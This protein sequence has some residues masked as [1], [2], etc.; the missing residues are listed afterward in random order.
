MEVLSPKR[1]EVWWIAF[2]PSV[3][4]EIQKTRPA[5]IISNDKSNRYLDRFQVIP[6]TPQTDRVYPGEAI[7]EL[8]GVSVKV[9]CN[10]LSTSSIRRFE[11]KYATVTKVQM[12]DIETALTTQLGLVQ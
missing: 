11:K 10:Q 3:G 2:D 4:S 9:M 8:H 7:I 6:I 5:V 1:G 12:F